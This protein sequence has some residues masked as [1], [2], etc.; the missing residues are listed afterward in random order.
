M[1]DHG[2]IQTR[3]FIFREFL[4]A[5]DVSMCALHNYLGYCYVQG[6]HS[7]SQ[8]Q[9]QW[10]Y[11]VTLHLQNTVIVQK[12]SADKTGGGAGMYYQ[13][14]AVQNGAQGPTI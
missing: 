11:H 7:V 8:R 14:L 13:G 4:Q 12:N 2:H 6:T 3:K 5:A 10:P 9:S 1:G